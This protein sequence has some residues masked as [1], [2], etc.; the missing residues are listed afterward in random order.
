MQRYIIKRLLLLPVLLLVFSVI[1]FILIQAP[2]GDFLTS[3]IAELAAS[4]S[5]MDRAQIDALRALYGLDQN[6]CK[7]FAAQCLQ[8]RRLIERGVRFVQIY[9]GGN[10][11]Q[12]EHKAEKKAENAE[13]PQLPSA[14][15]EEVAQSQG[16]V[17]D[18]LASLGF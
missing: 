9:S 2:P 14:N 18:L 16:D 1:A 15:K 3:Y 13:G 12:P 17:D 11:N 8:A 4:G 10:A 7:H 6:H 5:S